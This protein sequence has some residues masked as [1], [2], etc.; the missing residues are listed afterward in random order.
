M[1]CVQRQGVLSAKQPQLIVGVIICHV[2]VWLQPLLNQKKES[3]VITWVFPSV[4]S[5]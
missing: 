4:I 5:K 1:T 3:V 2:N